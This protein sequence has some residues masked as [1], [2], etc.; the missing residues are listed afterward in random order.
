MEKFLN[1]LKRGF[2]LVD[3]QGKVKFASAFLVEKELISPAWEGRRYY[4]AIRSFDLIRV[5][6]DTFS[7]KKGQEASFRHREDLFKAVSFLDGEVFV[8]VSPVSEEVRIER[9]VK[10]F[11]ANVAHE[12][13][14]P[15]TV[16]KGA[17][18]T[19][20]EETEDPER[21]K[22]VERAKERVEGIV[23][24]VESLYTLVSLER[25]RPKELRRIN[26]R[27]V[28]EE[29]I[30][31]LSHAIKGK[32]IEVRIDVSEEETVEADP[33]KFY[34]MLRNIV[35]NAV[36]HNVEGGKIEIK[37]KSEGGR[38]VIEVR[39]TGVGIEKRHI[40][41]IFEP[42]FKGSGEKGLGIGLAISK[43]IADFHGAKIEVES[44]VGKGSLFRI[45]L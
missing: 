12:I 37:V 27:E 7:E 24:V 29:I 15:L 39:D 5:V 43:K 32:G 9:K 45:I 30:G 10:E 22:M 16:V 42:F 18:E 17:L 26:L 35:D 4:E 2:L 11:L 34:I 1:R 23:S 25:E 14:T 40:P 6:H 21:R 41:L 36:K 33:E 31:E 44:E 38:K 3:T 28:F 13:R 8:E 19:L 20:L